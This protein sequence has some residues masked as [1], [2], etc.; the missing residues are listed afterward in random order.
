MFQKRKYKSTP[1]SL[2]VPLSFP[3]IQSLSALL[4]FSIKTPGSA[5]HWL[6]LSKSEL[7]QRVVM[8]IYID[9]TTSG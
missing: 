1:I 8:S 5:P 9:K 2:S 7:D 6:I 3:R 4:S